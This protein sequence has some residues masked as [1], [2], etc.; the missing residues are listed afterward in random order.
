MRISHTQDTVLDYARELGVELQAFVD[1][2]SATSLVSAAGE[3]P[4]QKMNYGLA[5]ASVNGYLSQFL[6]DAVERGYT[7]PGVDLDTLKRF[8]NDWGPLEEGQYL[9]SDR[10]G[11]EIPPGPGLQTG[12]EFPVPPANDLLGLFDRLRSGGNGFSPHRERPNRR[13]RL[14]THHAPPH[15]WDVN[16]RGRFRQSGRSARRVHSYEQPDHHRE[17]EWTRR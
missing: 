8:L 10:S 17:A 9:G 1:Y 12:T 14:A 16:H 4:Q 11:Y 6:L 13:V 7:P 2:N 15:E 5:L 3:A